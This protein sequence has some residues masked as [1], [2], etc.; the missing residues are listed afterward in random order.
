MGADQAGDHAAAV[1]IADQHHRRIGRAGEAHVGDVAGAQ[2]DLGRAAGAFHQHD[3]R[4]G[5][6]RAKLSST[7]RQQRGF[8]AW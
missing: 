3:V 4:L 5:R 7:V 6:S 1:D 2:V 8:I